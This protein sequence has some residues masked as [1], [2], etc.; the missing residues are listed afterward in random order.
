MFWIKAHARTEAHVGYSKCQS[1]DT[2]F[3]TAVPLMTWSPSLVTE[4]LPWALFCL[5]THSRHCY[6][7]PSKLD[8]KMLIVSSN[9]SS[10]YASKKYGPNRGRGSIILKITKVLWEWKIWCFHGRLHIAPTAFSLLPIAARKYHKMDEYFYFAFPC[11]IHTHLLEV[12]SDICHGSLA[13][14][15]LKHW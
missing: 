8:G 4:E 5:S 15:I 7:H 6:T 13:A 9:L 12:C 1:F 11:H 3:V 2:H 14:S 10:P